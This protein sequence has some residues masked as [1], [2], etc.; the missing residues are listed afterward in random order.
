MSMPVTTPR[1]PTISVVICV[2][3]EERWLDI[4]AALESVRAQTVRPLETIVVVDHN[5]MLRQRLEALGEDVAIVE[6]VQERGL[7]GAR[8]SGV[9]V[10]RGSIVAFLDDDAAAERDWLARL[11]QWYQDAAVLGVGGAAAPSWA[12]G[13]RPAWFPEEFDWVVGC[14][15]RGLPESAAPVRNLMGGTMS[16]RRDVLD[17]LGGF[18]CGIGRIGKRPLGCEETEL[19]I[20][21]RK[22]WPQGVFIYE[23]LARI[24]HRV[25]VLRSRPAYFVSRC[26][27]EGL[28]KGRVAELVGATDALAAE[29]IHALR[30]IPA[31]AVRAIRDAAAQRSLAPV[32]R[33]AALVGGVG[34][35][36]AGYLAYFANSRWQRLS[37]SLDRSRS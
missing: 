9:A 1:S 35:T 16:I 3:T 4:V 36:A 17:G 32:G 34:I 14:S 29:R 10:S 37:E 18:R 12:A 13:G 6:N 2:Y 11:V 28:S 19:C 33:A 30:T 27:A 22:R 31:G 23:P 25:P 21:A 8:N 26:Y 5:P 7:S 24:R 15:Y 20:R